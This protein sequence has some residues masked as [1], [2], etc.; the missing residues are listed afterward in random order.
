MFI[1]DPVCGKRL[2][3]N[4]AHIA[5]VYRRHVYYLCCSQCQAA[6]ERDPETYVRAADAAAATRRK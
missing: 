6:F 4:K 2:N 5:I 3:R 1:Y